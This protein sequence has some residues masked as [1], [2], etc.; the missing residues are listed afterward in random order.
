MVELTFISRGCPREEGGYG[1]PKKPGNLFIGPYTFEPI[2][3]CACDRSGRPDSNG[4]WLLETYRNET[5]S[6]EEIDPYLEKTRTEGGIHPLSSPT[7]QQG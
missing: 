2:S 1:S 5:V 7:K 6:Q 3:W 4:G